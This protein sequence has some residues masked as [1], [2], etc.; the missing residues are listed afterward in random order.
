MFLLFI[1]TP[2]VLDGSLF[3]LPALCVK[4]GPYGCD[5]QEHIVPDRIDRLE[6]CVEPELP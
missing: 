4:G 5:E 6:I 2:E 3:P 1:Q